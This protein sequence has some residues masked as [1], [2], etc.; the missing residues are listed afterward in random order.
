MQPE[1]KEESLTDWL[2]FDVSQKIPRITYKSF[3]RHKEA[4]QTG[5][6]WEWWFLF[7]SFALKMRVQ[8]K[9]LSS[10]R[11][12]YPCIAHTN[13]HG[14]QIEK[15]LH[16]ADQNNSMPFY[17]FYT[18]EY[19]DVMCRR[20]RNDEGVFMAGGHRIYDEVILKPRKTISSSEL[21]KHTI[22]LSCFLC[23]PLASGRARAGGLSGSD[24]EDGWRLF[25]KQYYTSELKQDSPNGYISGESIPG[26][27][28]RIPPYSGVCLGK[29]KGCARPVGKGVQEQ[30]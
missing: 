21:L 18:A 1:V 4:R 8:A 10:T 19:A 15:L 2:L 25:I 28:K 17:A 7:P 24:D 12:N 16:D 3:S 11:D 5:V 6:D 23:C 9:K 20:S 13:M 14:L 27:H 29:G 30:Y 26:I 22:A